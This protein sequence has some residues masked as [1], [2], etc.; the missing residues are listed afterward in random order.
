M[1]LLFAQTTLEDSLVLENKISS[2]EIKLFSF[3]WSKNGKISLSSLW[4]TLGESTSHLEYII[5]DTVE[6]KTIYKKMSTINAKKDTINLKDVLPDILAKKNK[7]NGIKAKNNL[8]F[9]T[10]PLIINTEKYDLDK[11]GNKLYLSNSLFGDKVITENV[12]LKNWQVL[13]AIKSP[14]EERIVIVFFDNSVA[15]DKN[16]FVFIGSH[17]DIGFTLE[18]KKKISENNI[19]EIELAIR[20]N[21]REVVKSFYKDMSPAQKKASLAFDG[22]S[23]VLILAAE[24]QNWQIVD[25]LIAQGIDLSVENKENTKFKKILIENKENKE[26]QKIV[27]K[28]SIKR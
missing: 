13:G 16:P 17:L 6:D 18:N 8:K 20:N 23:S 28:W 12:R 27:Q 14:F 15:K 24:Q 22:T 2:K 19:D 3:G 7:S 1:P 9:Y 21:Q 26:V 4:K 5:F 25:F 11:K 10:F